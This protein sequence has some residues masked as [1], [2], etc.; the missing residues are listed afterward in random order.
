M[1][2]KTEALQQRLIDFGVD[3]SEYAVRLQRARVTANIGTQLAR[4]CLSPAGNYSEAQNAES[5]RDFIHKMQVCLKELGET[6][7]WLRAAL[8]RDPNGEELKR[9][10]KECGELVAIFTAAVKTAKGRM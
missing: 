10:V 3:V 7:V 6:Q 9:L 8:R 2:T 1:H 4:S 5:K